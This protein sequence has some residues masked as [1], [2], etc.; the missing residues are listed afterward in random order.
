MSESGAKHRRW[1][2]WAARLLILAVLLLLGFF[3]WE[4][5][6]TEVCLFVACRSKKAV[7]DN[8]GCK[9]LSWLGPRAVPYVVP[10][11]KQPPTVSHV[12]PYFEPPAHAAREFYS[13]WFVVEQWHNLTPELRDQVA[14]VLFQIAS[15]VRSHYRP[16]MS[17]PYEVRASAVGPFS[18][19]PRL[20]VRVDLLKG[21]LL[22]ASY[23]NEHAG[24]EHGP[25]FGGG[26]LPVLRVSPPGLQGV[27]GSDEVMKHLQE[28][29][30]YTF[31]ITVTLA[32]PNTSAHFVT[33]EM[34]HGVLVAGDLPAESFTG[35]SNATLDRKMKNCFRVNAALT[36]DGKALEY[37][38]RKVAEPPVLFFR[39]TVIRIKETGQE[40]A[41]SHRGTYYNHL[42]RVVEPF[43]LSRLPLEPGRICH[44]Q[45]V[46][47]SD[48]DEAWRRP[49]VTRYWDGELASNWVEVTV[50]ELEEE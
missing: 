16:G 3:F 47:I 10:Y 13:V 42:G 43:Y 48:V 39:R 19:V 33:E 21:G 1:P 50:P 23:E 2:K 28:P 35:V 4:W 22:L 34:D 29:G 17:F 25:W 40:I 27:P 37:V 32:D 15:S 7:Y 46:I 14:P 30:Q 45:V 36:K 24:F 12:V 8:P 11:L 44:L 41:P 9:G 38:L 49:S 26:F 5:L 18:L 6:A 31:R 20:Q